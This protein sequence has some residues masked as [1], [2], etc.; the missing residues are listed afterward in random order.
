MACLINW[1]KSE[2]NPIQQLIFVGVHFDLLECT[3]WPTTEKLTHLWPKSLPSSTANPFQHKHGRVYWDSWTSSCRTV[4]K[5]IPTTFQSQYGRRPEK[6]SSSGWTMRISSK[7]VQSTNPLT[8]TGSV[9]MSPWR[10]GVLIW[11]NAKFMDGPSRN[12]PFTSTSWK[13]EPSGMLS[14]SSTLL[15]TLVSSDNG[16]PR[17]CSSPGG[18]VVATG[19][20]YHTMSKLCRVV[21]YT[22]YP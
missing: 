18:V 2:L 3:V 8:S 1:Y 4:H 11:T 15:Q 20:Y 19:P 21:T 10:D 12:S 16:R 7:S 13:W 17:V 22:V 6:Q 14:Y 9:Q 5:K